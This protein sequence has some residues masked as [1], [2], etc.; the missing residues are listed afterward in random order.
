MQLPKPPEI[1]LPQCDSKAEETPVETSN[2]INER[3][4]RAKVGMVA[5]IDKTFAVWVLKSYV[6]LVHTQIF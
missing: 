2:K 6:Q 1:L 4:R 3:K 5:E